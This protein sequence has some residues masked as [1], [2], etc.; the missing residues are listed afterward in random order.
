LFFHDVAIRNGVL[1][2][3]VPENDK[4]MASSHFRP[5]IDSEVSAA[6]YEFNQQ[7]A[8]EAAL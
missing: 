6:L 8:E 7:E 2:C 4:M 5:P 1:D 3:E